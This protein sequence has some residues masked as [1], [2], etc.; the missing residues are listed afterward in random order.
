MEG[1][2]CGG[3]Q[4]LGI[5]T[6]GVLRLS[7]ADGKFAEAPAREAGKVLLRAFR[8]FDRVRAVDLLR[9]FADLFFNRVVGFVGG[10]Q[11]EGRIAVDYFD[12]FLCKCDCSLGALCVGL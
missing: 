9:Y 5:V 12:D 4:T 10:R 7:D 1:P 11:L 3:A 8:E 2:S 6:Q